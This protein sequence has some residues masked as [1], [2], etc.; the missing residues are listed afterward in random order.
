MVTPFSKMVLSITP[1]AEHLAD[2]LVHG[3]DGLVSAALPANPLPSPGMKN[4]SSIK[5]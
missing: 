4:I 1:L 3:S 5:L 2:H